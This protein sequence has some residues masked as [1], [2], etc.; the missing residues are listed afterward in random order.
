LDIGFPCLSRAA[1]SPN[2]AAK[3]TMPQKGIKLCRLRPWLNPMVRPFSI[4]VDGTRHER[5]QR[6]S[7]EGPTPSGQLGITHDE[8]SA[9][10]LSFRVPK[11]ER[12][13]A[14]RHRHGLI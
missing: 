11:E 1:P 5:G 7:P 10:P 4:I 12:P 13:S 3:C 2:V 14:I 8:C 6:P 9:W